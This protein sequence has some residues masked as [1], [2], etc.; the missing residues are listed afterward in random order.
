MSV[1]IWSYRSEK[2]KLAIDPTNR[3][4]FHSETSFLRLVSSDSY[5]SQRTLPSERFFQTKLNVELIKLWKDKQWIIIWIVR[6]KS[7]ISINHN[8]RRETKSLTQHRALIFSRLLKWRPNLKP[9]RFEYLF[10]WLMVFIRKNRKKTHCSSSFQR[11]L[12]R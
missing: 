4:I 5:I 8:S 10:C 11:H 1:F 3:G 9:I 2:C 12:R 7:R 6:M